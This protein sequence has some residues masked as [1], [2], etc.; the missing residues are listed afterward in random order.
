VGGGGGRRKRAERGTRVSREKKAGGKN[1]KSKE[2][3]TIARS[4]ALKKKTRFRG[5]TTIP[6]WR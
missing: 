6:F 2:A 5:R 1:M 3:F 4:D